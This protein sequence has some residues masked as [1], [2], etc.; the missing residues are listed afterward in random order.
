MNSRD[1]WIAAFPYRDEAAQ[2]IAYLCTAWREL[3][4]N[5][6]ATFNADE[7]EPRLT[8]M[9][10]IHIHATAKVRA[11]LR[12]RWGYENPHGRIKKGRVTDRVRTDIEY[13][14]N[15]QDDAELELTVEF[16]RLD[17][18]ESLRKKYY[19][20]GGMGRFVTGEYSLKNPIALMAGILLDDRAT[21]VE[22][23]RKALLIAG[24]RAALNMVAD[25]SKQY[26][27]H[28]SALFPND[29]AFDTE[30]QREK[31]KAPTHGT[32]RIS[33]LFLTFPNPPTKLRRKRQRQSDARSVANSDDAS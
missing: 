18:Q 16:K 22:A 14:S 1:A 11:G 33:H 2:A 13:W 23:L 7:T 6:S 12:G 8:E 25:G 9:L 31:D 20:E 29:A 4:I 32:I 17:A 5:E 19:G 26:L 24:V 21:C 30:H 3:T 15:R 10:G 28:P 27:R